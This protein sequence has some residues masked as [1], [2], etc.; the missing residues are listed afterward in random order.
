MTLPAPFKVCIPSRGRARIGIAAYS[1][2]HLREVLRKKYD[3]GGDFCLQQDDGT[4]VCDEDYFKLLE[5]NTLLTVVESENA[6]AILTSGEGKI[7]RGYLSAV[8]FTPTYK[9][10]IPRSLLLHSANPE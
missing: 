3:V 1:Y 7:M 8:F 9:N 4:L 10:K 5:P 2:E 6:A